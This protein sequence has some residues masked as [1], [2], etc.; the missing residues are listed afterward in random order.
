MQPFSHEFN[1]LLMRERE[2]VARGL[3]EVIGARS[4]SPRA[5]GRRSGW[6]GRFMGLPGRGL[7]AVRRWLSPGLQEDP[8]I[9]ID[10]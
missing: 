1:Y 9:A 3:A 2:T 7:A 5:T 10:A 8:P 6:L 4:D